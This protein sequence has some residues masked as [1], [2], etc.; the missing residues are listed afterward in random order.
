MFSRS[1]A[2]PLSPLPISRSLRASVSPSPFS[3]IFL[4]LPEPLEDGRKD[5]IGNEAVSRSDEACARTRRA[6][7]RPHGSR[8]GLRLRLSDAV[9]FE[10]GV[11]ISHDEEAPP[12]IDHIRVVVVSTRRD[13]HQISERPRRDYLERMGG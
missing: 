7:R 9:R 13:E 6:K 11:P 10:P 12:E 4:V 2:P 8:D 5:A 3:V 1:P